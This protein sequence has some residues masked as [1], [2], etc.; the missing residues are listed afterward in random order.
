MKKLVFVLVFV[1]LVGLAGAVSGGNKA[2]DNPDARGVRVIEGEQLRSGNYITMEGKKVSLVKQKE[3]KIMIGAGDAFADSELEIS[4]EMIENR[5]KLK[6]KLSNGRNAEIKIM[7][8][9]ASA[10]ALERL[11]IK[12]CNES[13]NC[14]I[15]LKEVGS[16]NTTRMSYEVRAVKKAKVLGFFNAKMSVRSEVDAETGVVRNVKKPWW[17]VLV[18]ESED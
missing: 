13:N 14:T 2:G 8:D 6:A 3:N 5:A 17:S 18:S 11:G 12:V 4:S 7:P 9:V 10:R 15:Q 1:L 16:G